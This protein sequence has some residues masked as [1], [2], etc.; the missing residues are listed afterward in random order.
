MKTITLAALLLLLTGCASRV[1]PAR[2]D[3]DRWT[4]PPNTD[5]YADEGKAFKT[6]KDYVYCMPRPDK[7]PAQD[8]D[9][10]MQTDER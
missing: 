7:A 1:R 2:W 3:G 10:T 6:G 8:Q 4:C 9:R 5:E